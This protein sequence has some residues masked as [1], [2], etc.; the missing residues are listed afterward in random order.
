MLRRTGVSRAEAV[1]HR[2]M[3]CRH[4]LTLQLAGFGAVC[5]LLPSAW[6]APP[7]AQQLANARVAALGWL[8]VNQAGDGS[9]WAVDANG[10]DGPSVR[11]T[12]AVLT[13]VRNAGLRDGFL[14][15]GAMDYLRG[16]QARSTDELA[17][18]VAALASAGVPE[19]ALRNALQANRNANYAWGAY[20]GFGSSLPDTPLAVSAAIQ[21][22]TYDTA[23]TTT[24]LCFGVLYARQANGGFAY[25]VNGTSTPTN[26][27]GSELIPT[28]SAIVALRDIVT[29]Y[30]TSQL[31]CT[32]L[33]NGSFVTTQFVLGTV[34]SGAATWLLTQQNAGGG[35][36]PGGVSNALDTALAYQALSRISPTTYATQL[37][38]AANYLV[39][40]QSA[41][42]S[43]SGDPF[44]TGLAL[45]TLPTLS[46][47]SLADADGDG[48]PDLVET[49]IG[50]NSAVADRAQVTG[51]GQ[52][53]T[54]V[55][56]AL[57]L[58]QGT[59]R[60]VYSGQLPASGTSPSAFTLVAGQLPPGL[61]LDP[62]TGALTGTPS[63]SGT[64]N[65]SYTVTTAEGTETRTVQI[66]VAPGVPVPLPPWTP[67]LLAAA[68]L[69]AASRRR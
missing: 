26:L 17:R 56:T 32:R 29:T 24:T 13:A 14:V 42:G 5:T 55:T 61:M 49:G 57:S 19:T 69:R 6:A 67:L 31:S 30:G 54:S 58:T 10:Q 3:R 46:A 33:D 7:T 21:S 36:G 66:Q 52:A 65:F 63:V 8:A 16:A 59:Q 48:L 34:V 38:E 12:A 37:G 4:L 9:F 23:H 40:T 60:G 43:W 25:L 22:L 62:N 35:F 44:T 68:L 51:N 27:A 53:E 45:G 50:Q 1:C 39:T 28:A 20:P 15:R 11:A 64:F 41:N 18:Q 47:G 2:A